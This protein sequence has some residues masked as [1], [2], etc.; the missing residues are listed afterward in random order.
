MKNSSWDPWSQ[1]ITLAARN[2]L[3]SI[4]KIIK[5]NKLRVLNR[6][7]LLCISLCLRDLFRQLEAYGILHERAYSTS[8]I[9]NSPGCHPSLKTLGV[10]VSTDKMWHTI[11]NTTLQALFQKTGSLKLHLLLTCF[12]DLGWF[13]Y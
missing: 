13:L 7:I 3:L 6:M 8:G 4:K 11:I 9:A 1:R 10:T 12:H 5:N 2:S